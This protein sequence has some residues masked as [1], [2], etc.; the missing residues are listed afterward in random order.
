MTRLKLLAVLPLLLFAMKPAPPKITTQPVSVT[1]TA[2]TPA[3][4]KVVASGSKLSYQWLQNSANI[5]GATLASYTT[6][7]TTS[8]LNGATF[9]V[10]V[11]NATATV[12]SGVATLTVVAASQTIT[13]SATF[14]LAQATV[15]TAYSANIATAA[16][17]QLNGVA[18]TTCSYAIT[19]GTA[20]AGLTLS[21]AGVL[22]GTPTTT[23][24]ASFTIQVTAPSG[25]KNKI[26]VNTSAH[27]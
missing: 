8:V 20:P 25:A 15:G 11:S 7:P 10:K 6:P 12:T 9:Q 1:V 23:G 17:V 24:T 26:R 27:H 13:M 4:F 2:P 21:T 22:A 19:T 3:T 5:A 16:N 18:C 14:T